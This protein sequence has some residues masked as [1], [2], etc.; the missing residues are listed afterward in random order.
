MMEVDTRNVSDFYK[1]RSE[2]AIRSDLDSKRN[3]FVTVVERVNGDFNFATIVRNNNAFLGEKVIR[4][5]I[6]RWDKRGSVG[7]HHYE[8]ME[9]ADSILDVLSYYRNYGYRIVAIDNVGDAK[10]INEYS[11]FIKSVHNSIKIKEILLFS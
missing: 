6:K 5:G 2:D 9:Y 3:S 4:C 8:H 1:Y 10:V 7:A 11:W